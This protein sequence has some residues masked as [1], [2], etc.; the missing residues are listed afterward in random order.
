MQCAHT[1]Q[2]VQV[3]DLKGANYNIKPN[4]LNNKTGFLIPLAQFLDMIN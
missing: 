2:T 3:T 1:Q 4:I